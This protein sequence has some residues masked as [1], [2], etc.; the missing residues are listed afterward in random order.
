MQFL[1]YLAKPTLWECFLKDDNRELKLGNMNSGAAIPRASWLRKFPFH[2]LSAFRRLAQIPIVAAYWSCQWKSLWVI[3]HSPSHLRRVNTSE[4]RALAPAS[5]PDQRCTSRCT[6]AMLSMISM[7]ANRGLI[8]GAGPFSVH[9]F[10]T[11]LME[12]LYWTPFNNPAMGSDGWNA[13]GSD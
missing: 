2:D 3:F 12:P 13:G 4:A 7:R 1:S 9:H 6:T 5:L 8:F 11:G 10:N